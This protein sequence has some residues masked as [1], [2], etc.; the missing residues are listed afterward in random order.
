M[1]YLV[2]DTEATNLTPGQICQLSYLMIEEGVVR[3]KNMFF[4]VDDMSPGAEEVHGMSMDDLDRLS[5]GERFA[6]RADEIFD[7]F[8]RADMLIG[9]NVS[10]DIRYIRAEFER[11][12]MTPKKHKTFCTMN[13]FTSDTQLGKR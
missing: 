13:H 7:D 1:V 12:G 10:A 4:A 6:D 3:G 5:G 9:H 2:F 11:L 8:A